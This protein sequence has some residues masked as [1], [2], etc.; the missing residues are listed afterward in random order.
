MIVEL[1]NFPDNYGPNLAVP[2]TGDS[3]SDS[4]ALH[5]HFYYITINDKIFPN[6]VIW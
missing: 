2:F 3:V 6:R 5:L 1:E 4:D